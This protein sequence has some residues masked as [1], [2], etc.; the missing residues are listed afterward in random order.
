MKKIWRKNLN[1]SILYIKISSAPLKQEMSYNK[2]KILQMINDEFGQGFIKEV[3][4]GICHLLLT[5]CETFLLENRH[6]VCIESFV[7]FLKKVECCT[8]TNIQRFMAWLQ[9]VAFSAYT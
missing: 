9:G 4:I 2:A 3:I 7:L 6:A 5:A 1:K 8:V